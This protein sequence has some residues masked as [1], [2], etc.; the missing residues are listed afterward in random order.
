MP[1]LYSVSHDTVCKR[2]FVFFFLFFFVFFFFLFVV[3]CFENTFFRQFLY[4]VKKWKVQF[5]H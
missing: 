2:F 1:K 4:S 3:S 5:E